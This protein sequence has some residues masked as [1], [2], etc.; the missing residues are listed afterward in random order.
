MYIIIYTSATER[1]LLNGRPNMSV[2]RMPTQIGCHAKWLL[3][4]I[5]IRKGVA[6]SR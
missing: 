5:H 6:L 3:Y 1:V 2:L 4:V